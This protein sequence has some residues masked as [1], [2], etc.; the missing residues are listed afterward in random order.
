MAKCEFTHYYFVICLLV[1]KQFKK[2]K[3]IQLLFEMK[4]IKNK[5]ILLL[6]K[7]E[8]RCLNI[9]NVFNY[10]YACVFA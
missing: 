10:L 8:T 3:P 2:K 1:E 4:A 6:A 9:Y 5:T 7:C